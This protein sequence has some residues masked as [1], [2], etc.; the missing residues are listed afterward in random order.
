MHG[1]AP[2]W[3][4]P[5][6]R[7][8]DVSD[9]YLNRTPF[10]FYLFIGCLG[11]P[12]VATACEN[13]KSATSNVT[14]TRTMIFHVYRWPLLTAQGQCQVIRISNTENNGKARINYGRVRNC[15][16][17][18]LLWEICSKTVT[19]NWIWRVKY[20]QNLPLRDI[21]SFKQKAVWDVTVWFAKRRSIRTACGLRLW[22][23]RWVNPENNLHQ[24]LPYKWSWFRIVCLPNVRTNKI[25]SRQL[26]F[27]IRVIWMT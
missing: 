2:S 22:L 6:I 15:A 27:Q 19:C 26:L 10:R 24:L 12:I 14:M 11:A 3:R 1:N 13:R 17:N 7:R 18:V 4:S 16:F 20:N 8:L 23:I 9:E 25:G 21:L 5:E